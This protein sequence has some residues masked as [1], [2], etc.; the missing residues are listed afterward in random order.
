M[1]ELRKAYLAAELKVHP[2]KNK[3]PDATEASQKVKE[4]YRI[5]SQP[6]KHRSYR[7]QYS[8]FYKEWE[9][10]WQE[11][12]AEKEKRKKSQQQQ[13]EKARKEREEQRFRDEEDEE[14]KRHWDEL[15]KKYQ[16]QQEEKS[17]K[18]DSKSGEKKDEP[19]S[20]KAN[21]VIIGLVPS[22]KRFRFR[23]LRRFNRKVNNAWNPNPSN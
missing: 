22:M 4:A 5:L 16:K 21:V 11:E 1:G 14:F 9:R 17:Q 15:R 3:S 13:K 12:K 8:G 23:R 19:T 2:D 18:P 7:N 6:A 20:T 10:Q